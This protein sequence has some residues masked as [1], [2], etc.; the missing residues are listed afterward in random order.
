MYL[1]KPA[2]NLL[3]LKELIFSSNLHLVSGNECQN[4]DSWDLG[5]G[6]TCSYI[7]NRYDNYQAKCEMLLGTLTRNEAQITEL[8]EN[9]PIFCDTCPVLT[10]TSPTTVFQGR[11]YTIGAPNVTFEDKEGQ[12][13]LEFDY[14]VGK[15]ATSSKFSIYQANCTSAIPPTDAVLSIDGP[16]QRAAN[17]NGDPHTYIVNVDEAEFSDSD[18]VSEVDGKG[19]SKGVLRFCAKIEG[20]LDITSVTFEK[21]NI[22]L[23]YDLTDNSFSVKENSIQADD[24]KETETTIS[25]KYGVDAFRCGT[26]DGEKIDGATKLEQNSLVGI[27][28]EPLPNSTSAVKISNFDMNFTQEGVFVFAAAEF[29]TS[30]PK[31][32]SALSQVT[33]FDNDGVIRHKVVSRLITALFD[34]EETAF[35]VV[36]NAYLEFKT[37]ARNL[38]QL[39]DYVEGSAED[40]PFSLSIEI[41]KTASGTS[42]EKMKSSLVFSV[43][44]ATLAVTVG[45]VLYKKLA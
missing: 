32:A 1:S 44:G 5:G 20:M 6:F 29:G 13:K 3:L 19:N 16:E 45:F 37:T 21:T 7:T 30:A 18:L 33:S 42:D 24:I 11:N 34:G 28:L 38:R 26:S 25:T 14:N 8:K 17:S 15:D 10:T 41:K 27:C 12:F 43:V 40:A 2:I 22:E 4:D 39:N 9:C 23:S 35:D 36:G 31:K